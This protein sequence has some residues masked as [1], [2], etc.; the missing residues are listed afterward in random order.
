MI[1]HDNLDLELTA[2][3]NDLLNDEGST[4]PNQSLQINQKKRR[5]LVKVEEPDIDDDGNQFGNVVLPVL[6]CV[7]MIRRRV[8]ALFIMSMVI[9]TIPVTNIS[10]IS[11]NI[12]RGFNYCISSQ[13]PDST[14]YR[15]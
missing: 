14:T 3:I 13:V 9:K 8:I 2:L 11:Y 5:S 10:K 6:K 15:T 7:D 4:C 1:N 12:S